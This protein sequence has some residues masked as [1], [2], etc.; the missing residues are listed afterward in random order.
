MADTIPDECQLCRLL[1]YRGDDINDPT[2]STM[3]ANDGG[4]IKFIYACRRCFEEMG[5]FGDPATTPIL[6]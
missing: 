2:H 1:D 4:G 6:R 5:W 3:I